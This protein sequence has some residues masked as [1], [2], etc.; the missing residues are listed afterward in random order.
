MGLKSHTTER[1]GEW[2]PRQATRLLKSPSTMVR[3]KIE[4]TEGKCNS[5]GSKRGGCIT[6]APLPAELHLQE[7]HESECGSTRCHKK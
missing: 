5:L 3:T 7:G 2:E 1:S 4:L 6:A